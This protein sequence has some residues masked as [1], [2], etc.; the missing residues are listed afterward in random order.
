M[1]RFDFAWPER[2][3]ALEIQGAVWTGGKHARGA[4]MVKDYEKANAA[5]LLGWRLLY[6]EATMIRSCAILDTLE[7]ILLED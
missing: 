2:R 1:W 4:G 3:I 6:A 5:A 7:A